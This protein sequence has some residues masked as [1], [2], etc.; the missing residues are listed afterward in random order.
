MT[1]G[2]FALGISTLGIFALGLHWGTI[3]EEEG[4]RE[5]EILNKNKKIERQKTFWPHEFNFVQ[6]ITS[7][8]FTATKKR[9]LEFN[10]PPFFE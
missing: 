8:V 2:L 9:D 3:T 6:R 10:W 7:H 1:Q 4:L 5:K